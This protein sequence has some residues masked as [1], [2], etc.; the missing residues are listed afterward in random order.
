V[1]TI[2]NYHAKILAQHFGSA[3][4]IFQASQSHLENLEGIGPARARAIRSF[5]KFHIAEKES[6]FVARYGINTLF[7][8]DA[9]Y[10]A[11]LLHCYDPPAL[12]F[13]KGTAPLNP[14][15]A[16]AIVGTRNNSSY[17]KQAT[18]RIVQQLAAYDVT[19]VS[20]LAFGIDAIAH[21][22]SLNNGLPTIGVMAHG[23]DTIYPPEH[24]S[25]ARSM[26]QA[27]GI[28][29]EFKSNTTPEKY[30]FPS[31]NRIVAGMTNATIVIESGIKGGSMIT[32]EMASGYDKDVFAVPGRLT[33][34]KSSG[35]NHLI[36]KNKAI[37]FEDVAELALTLGW[38]AP[39]IRS[40][41][42]QK[43]IF[44]DLSNT[45]KDLVALLQSK[46][47]MAI[48]ELNLQSGVSLSHLAA[49]L[50]KLE[51]NFITERLPG[52]MYRIRY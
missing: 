22:A 52:K 50:L 24:A 34:R 38:D 1:P 45:E 43:N 19:I 35:C 25:L 51:L 36:N 31:R 44:T 48:D 23:L 9:G 41:T 7:L 39:E 27:G 13:Y 4:R 10:P 2:G 33:D 29:T 16:I 32:A 26:M 42:V 20:G 18:E 49:A 14:A 47:P 37:I 6:N 28:L 40:Q 46:G 3:T 15:R 8:T 12:L 11:R 21:R 17:G 5:N 30:N